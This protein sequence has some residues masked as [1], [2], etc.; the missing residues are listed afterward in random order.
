MVKSGFVSTCRG[1]LYKNFG[2][3][4]EMFVIKDISSIYN[5]NIS[6]YMTK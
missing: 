1:I 6:Y 2:F 3:I 4:I 5:I